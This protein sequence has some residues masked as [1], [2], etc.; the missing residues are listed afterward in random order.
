MLLSAKHKPG[1]TARGCQ[2]KPHFLAC[3][4]ATQKCSER[5]VCKHVPLQMYDLGDVL[6]HTGDTMPPYNAP[7]TQ[8]VTLLSGK[9]L[10]VT[11]SPL[12]TSSSSINFH[13]P[14]SISLCIGVL[15]PAYTCTFDSLR[16]CSISLV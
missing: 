4:S 10:P 14:I 9:R 16:T 15:L 7:S 3:K 6:L 12:C 2:Q 11:G 13:R 8:T 5:Y 1:L